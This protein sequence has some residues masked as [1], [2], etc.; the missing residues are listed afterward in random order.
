MMRQIDEWISP[1]KYIHNEMEN[2]II[3]SVLSSFTL[4]AMLWIYAKRSIHSTNYFIFAIRAKNEL[5]FAVYAEFGAIENF[6]NW[7]ACVKVMQFHLKTRK[8]QKIRKEIKTEQ[9]KKI[10][11]LIPAQLKQQYLASLLLE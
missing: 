11:K 6:L 3:H 8:K 5:I 7:N 1:A 9:K 10:R 4:S 2:T